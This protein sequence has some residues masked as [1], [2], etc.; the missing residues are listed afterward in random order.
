MKLARLSGK[1]RRALRGRSR[2]FT[3]IEVLVALALFGIIA[4][5]FAGGLGT[6]SRAVFTADI[7]VTAESLARSQMEYVKSQPLYHAAPWCYIVDTKESVKCGDSNRPDWSHYKLEPE[8]AGYS[9][10]IEAEEVYVGEDD[11]QQITV[12]VEHV[13]DTNRPVITLVGYNRKGQS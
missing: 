12:T 4:I 2:G 7:R 8:Y 9:A 11:I 10:R 6:A 1:A 5:V 13:S 3:L